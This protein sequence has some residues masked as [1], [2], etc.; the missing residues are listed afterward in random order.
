MS[1]CRVDRATGFRT[2][3]VLA[4]ESSWGAGPAIPSGLGLDFTTESLQTA[5]ANTGPIHIIN[6]SRAA[7]PALPG[8]EDAGGELNS[9]LLLGGAWAVLLKHALGPV[10]STSGSGPYVHV[11]DGQDQLPEGLTIDKVVSYRSATKNV[12]RYFGCKVNQFGLRSQLGTMVTTR[13]AILAKS[14]QRFTVPF[15]LAPSYVPLTPL[16]ARTGT[17]SC[18]LSGSGEQTLLG[19][20]QQFD[21]TIDN[22][23]NKDDYGPYAG[24]VR[25]SLLEGGR[26][27]TGSFTAMLTPDTFAIYE[28]QFDQIPFAIDLLFSAPPY[29][30]RLHIPQVQITS[31]PAPQVVQVGP[32]S[33]RGSFAAAK[34]DDANPEIRVTLVSAEPVLTT[35][36]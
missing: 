18:N 35:G 16:T 11:I 29:S 23:L 25:K 33:I 32:M 22:G 26:S 6:Q 28:R 31:A 9:E 14:E 34:K 5:V 19:S 7:Q 1:G 8:R 20:V 21:L 30:L 36:H 24:A 17:L 4:E 27:I 10:V 12:L 2:T 15:D 3:V 13:V